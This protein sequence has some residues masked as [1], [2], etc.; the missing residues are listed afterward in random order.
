M[1]ISFD[2]IADRYDSTRSFPEPIMRAILKDL[3]PLLGRGV[4]ILDAG[5]GTG[6]FAKPLQEM[7]HEVVGIDVSP[8][9]LSK[10][11]EKG[12]ADII[13]GDV[14]V[15]PFADAAFETTLSIHVLHLISKWM[16]ALR[17]FS[18]V[19]TGSLVSVET[20]RS[21]SPA[22]VIREMYDSTCAEL[23]YPVKHPGMRER[24]LPELLPPDRKRLVT[25]HEE[26]VDVQL[27][28][29]NMQNR[30]FSNQWSVPEDIHEEA[31]RRLRDEFEGNVRMAERERI[32]LLIWSM[33]RVRR[34]ASG[35]SAAEIA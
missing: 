7:G 12:V 16:C 8:K 25:V 4:R 1:T 32:S 18:R 9:M 15:L 27:T 10:A 29:L 35:P 2:R 21:G 30:S 3:D 17:E 22:E 19:T 23:G 34:F 13:R 24:E 5:V 6:R 26:P 14:C 28:I 20:D 31:I 33:D 11:R